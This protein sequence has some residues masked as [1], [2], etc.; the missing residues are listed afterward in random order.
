M[1]R[2]DAHGGDDGSPSGPFKLLS[3]LTDKFFFSFTKG[4][5]VLGS[6][7]ARKYFPF[8][9]ARAAVC[10][11]SSGIVCCPW[12]CCIVLFESE[13]RSRSVS[14]DVFPHSW[15]HSRRYSH[16][17][18]SQQAACPARVYAVGGLSCD[19]GQL[20]RPLV[21]AAV[22]STGAEPAHPGRRQVPCIPASPL[23]T[24]MAC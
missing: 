17:H 15:Q 6:L 19:G 8:K 11:N 22:A 16:R 10:R 14:V 1:A 7:L 5:V 13:P 18:R 4:S 3:L 23:P 21:V 20:S 24:S 2:Y 9:S 12:V